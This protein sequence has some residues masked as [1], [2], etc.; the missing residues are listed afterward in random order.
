M[1]IKNRPI[2]SGRN[3]KKKKQTMKQS[4]SL[5]E[6]WRY[7]DSSA[8]A[9]SE[10]LFWWPDSVII[11]FMVT[12]CFN[13]AVRYYLHKWCKSDANLH[14]ADLYLEPGD[15]WR[16]P[17]LPSSQEINMKVSLCLTGR[18][19]PEEAKRRTGAILC[20]APITGPFL[21]PDLASLFRTSFHASHVMFYMNN[22]GSSKGTQLK[23]TECT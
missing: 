10:N 3:W 16:H 6:C 12:P 15:V 21:S 23:T 4:L 17:C 7:W 19:K 9:Q 20:L 1:L 18:E 14:K 5:N 2:I 11:I 8:N 22:S 13:F